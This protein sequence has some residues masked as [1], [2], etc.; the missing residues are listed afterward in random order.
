MRRETS[1]P[2]SYKTM[3]SKTVLNSNKATWASET[4]HQSLAPPTVKNSQ[5]CFLLS[6][7]RR[8]T[9]PSPTTRI[10]SSNHHTTFV[11][12]LA[13]PN[14]WK[15]WKLR[16]VWAPACEK[17][18]LLWLG[19]ASQKD[20]NDQCLIQPISFQGTICSC[21]QSLYMPTGL[22]LS[23]KAVTTQLQQHKAPTDFWI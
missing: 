14:T 10:E 4:N 20:W 1:S 2:L 21:R 16:D 23:E 17:G 19:K 12:Y 7:G 6:Q 13:L 3:V 5:I 8:S 18:C 15:Y 9:V 22:P 11:E